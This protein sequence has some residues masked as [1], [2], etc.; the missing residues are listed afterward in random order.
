M[1]VQNANDLDKGKSLENHFLG[2][3][4]NNVLKC[5]NEA[6]KKIEYSRD[7]RFIDKNSE[8]SFH[9]TQQAE[10]DSNTQQSGNN[11][12]EID[13]D[14]NNDIS[15]PRRSERQ[16]KGVPPIRYGFDNVSSK[17]MDWYKSS[18]EEKGKK[19]TSSAEINDQ[20]NEINSES[21]SSYCAN[22]LN[23]I[24]S[25]NGISKP[26]SF[27]EAMNDENKDDWIEAMNDELNSL[28]KNNTWSITKLPA[29]RK[30]IGSKWVYD[31]KTNEHGEIIRY[32]ARLVAKGFSQKYGIDYNEIFAPVAKQTT[33]RILLSI[34]S[35]SFRC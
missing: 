20:N 28:K 12:D 26:S 21:E 17:Y 25:I 6:T 1:E 9:N 32:K 31:I 14:L 7:V 3:D 23:S 30:A 24:H 13:I 8:I 11:N 10:S 33:L 34:A 16:N 22:L 15:E 18:V 19:D 4:E 35:S 27:K 29:G 2:Y 5:Y